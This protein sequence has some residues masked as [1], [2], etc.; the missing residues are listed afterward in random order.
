MNKDSNYVLS[1]GKKFEDRLLRLNDFCNPHSFNFLQNA[2]LKKGDHI[3]DVGCGIG[4]LT[5]WL[6]EQ[7]GPKGSV[8]AI[9]ISPEQLELAQNR[10]KQRHLTN[11][12]FH[13]ISIYD[14]SK[15]KRTFDLVYS[16]FVIDHVVD[17]T[18]ALQAV[19]N[20]VRPHGTLC[21]ESAA[22]NT[23]VFF[24]YPQNLA[25]TQHMHWFEQLRKT[26]VYHTNFGIQLP[27]LLKQNGL[28]EV[29]LALVLPLLKTRFQRE[30]C[31]LLTEECAEDYQKNGIATKAEINEL[32]AALKHSIADDN[33]QLTF[34]IIAQ[35]V[36]KK[37]P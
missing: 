10:A 29:D 5:C 2:G 37:M 4:E 35:V 28:Y 31:I 25:Y 24:S 32:I 30:H 8:T 1:V 17:Q 20:L 16:R 11:I 13:E 9:D 6:A 33:L 7:V 34:F 26:V 27:L 21:L 19:I 3:I 18:K 15:L 22:F 36:A 14:L 23:S 12:E